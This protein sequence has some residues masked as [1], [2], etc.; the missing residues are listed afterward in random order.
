MRL[1][2]LP[3]ALVRTE[4]NPQSV[5]GKPLTTLETFGLAPAAKLAAGKPLAMFFFDARQR[6]SR[7]Q[8]EG[9]AAKAELWKKS[10]LVIL[11]VIP[12]GQAG[13]ASGD[14]LDAHHLPRV[15]A[16]LPADEILAQRCRAR[17]GVTALPHIVLTDVS[18]TVIAEGISVERLEALLNASGDAAEPAQAATAEKPA[19]A[20]AGE[21]Q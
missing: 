20:P 2:Q 10:G 15:V 4:I 9:L 17:W 16:S 21:N 1:Y 12:G 7:H 14:W 11:M 3:G 19:P 6:P 5:M 13:K 8:A 18:H